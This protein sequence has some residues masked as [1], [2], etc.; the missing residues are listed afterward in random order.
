MAETTVSWLTVV[1]LSTVAET[2]RQTD[3]SP[4]P[5]ADAF[6]AVNSP[7][8]SPRFPAPPPSCPSPPPTWQAAI[9]L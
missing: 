7:L 3:A 9:F 8:A 5:G 6:G 2:P 4:P 1:S